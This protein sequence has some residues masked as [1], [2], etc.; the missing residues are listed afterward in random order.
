MGL[1]ITPA[2]SLSLNSFPLLAG[3][4]LECEHFIV[5]YSDDKSGRHFIAEKLHWTLE[6]FSASGLYPKQVCMVVIF[7]VNAVTLGSIFWEGWEL[8]TSFLEVERAVLGLKEIQDKSHSVSVAALS[9]DPYP[10]LSFPGVGLPLPLPQP[11]I[12]I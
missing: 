12:L 1:L 2:I 3:S 5:T 11:L 6:T 10:N 4:S 8:P 7:H 9:T